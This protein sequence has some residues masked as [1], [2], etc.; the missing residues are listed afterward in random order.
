MRC[1]GG[2]VQSAVALMRLL[3]PHPHTLLAPCKQA[4]STAPCSAHHTA[5]P[6]PSGRIHADAAASSSDEEEEQLDE[7]ASYWGFV[8]HPAHL[9]LQRLRWQAYCGS[10]PLCPAWLLRQRSEGSEPRSCDCPHRCSKQDGACRA[11][12]LRH[13]C[14]LSS[15]CASAAGRH[16]AS[17]PAPASSA[18]PSLT[19][20][21]L[22]LH[23]FPPAAALPVLVLQQG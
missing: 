13:M 22:A 21:C 10:P 9:E 4:L 1:S 6:M 16:R 23:C 11:Q 3:H 7:Q 20:I 19:T 14:A 12:P 8:C 18:P 2:L 15:V 17:R 5:S